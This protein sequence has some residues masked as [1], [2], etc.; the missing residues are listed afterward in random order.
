MSTPIVN[1]MNLMKKLRPSEI[2]REAE[3]AA[4]RYIACCGV[5]SAEKVLKLAWQKVKA[6][7]TILKQKYGDKNEN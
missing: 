1:L 5:I 7:N 3:S 4:T 6:R 2:I